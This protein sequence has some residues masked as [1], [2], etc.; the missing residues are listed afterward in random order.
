MT[1]AACPTLEVGA[2][3]GLR[4]L[5][6][7]VDARGGES[8]RV[9]FRT[10]STSPFAAGTLRH[11]HGEAWDLLAGGESTRITWTDPDEALA[12]ALG[13]A[14][15]DV[16]VPSWPAPIAERLVRRHLSGP[17]TVAF[18]AGWFLSELATSPLDHPIVLLDAASKLGLA[19]LERA[20]TILST[21]TGRA[22]SLTELLVRALGAGAWSGEGRLIGEFHGGELAQ[23]GADIGDGCQAATGTGPLRVVFPPSEPM[24]L[25]LGP[26]LHTDDIQSAGTGCVVGEVDP[27]GAAER[28]GLR[29][30]MALSHL[31]NPRLDLPS[32]GP[33]ALS[34]EDVLDAIDTRRA[35]RRPLT[36]TFDTAAQATHLYAV[37]MPAAEALRALAETVGRGLWMRSRDVGVGAPLDALCGRTLLWREGTPRLFLGEA[38][39]VT[40][41]HTDMCPQV[42]MAHA[43]VGTKL[44]GVASHGATPRL[45]AEH[46]P[47]DDEPT[48]VPTDRPLTARSHRL[49]CDPE[50]TV[51]VLQAGDLAVFDSG[52]LHFASNGAEAISGALYH[53]LIT[54]AAVPRLRLAAA[55]HSGSEAPAG[56][57]YSGH[58]YP[59]ELLRLVERRLATLSRADDRSL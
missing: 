5:A 28:A 15:V 40:S 25:G 14:T 36:V 42:Q 35:R 54:P 29:P 20:A 30:G 33:G 57:A 27:G 51:V 52:A 43:L 4:L 59:P 58:L 56:G 10:S 37:E 19:G 18:D 39:S 17:G 31:S 1:I 44:V 24:G 53:G 12:L 8:Y 13:H 21:A 22:S 23:L 9:S 16:A 46:I 7:V 11:A 55:A 47:D 34:F 38:G 48:S 45:R 41:A 3:L 50:V 32:R 49:L 26:L 6:L 2:G